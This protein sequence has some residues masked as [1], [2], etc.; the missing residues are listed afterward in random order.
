[1]CVSPPPPRF[2]LQEGEMGFSGVPDVAGTDLFLSVYFIKLIYFV[3]SVDRKPNVQKF[4][5]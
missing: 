4:L 1:M 5:L 2:R 3:S